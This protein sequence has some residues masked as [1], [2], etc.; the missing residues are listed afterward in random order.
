MSKEELTL[1]ERID[2]FNKTA[3]EPIQLNDI[4]AWFGISRETE[5]TRFLNEKNIPTYKDE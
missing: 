4:Q 1:Q 3:K 2:I 5:M